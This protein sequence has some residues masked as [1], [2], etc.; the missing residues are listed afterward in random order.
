MTHAH[1]LCALA[2]DIIKKMELLSSQLKMDLKVRI[3]I[4]SGPVVAG[5]IGIKKFFYDVYGDTVNLASR[6]LSH[7]VV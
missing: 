2:L 4:A 1:T 7:G 6:M 5:V 3:G